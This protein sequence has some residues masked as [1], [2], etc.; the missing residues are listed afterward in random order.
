MKLSILIALLCVL[1]TIGMDDAPE[2]TEIEFTDDCIKTYR[3]GFIYGSFAAL[4]I[5]GPCICLPLIAASVISAPVAIGITLGCG[6]VGG[7]YGTLIGIACCTEPDKPIRI[8]KQLN[9]TT[10]QQSE[11]TNVVVQK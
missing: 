11:L 3:L 9:S 7:A 5:T 8:T 1:P 6:A 4:G 2:Q 10:T